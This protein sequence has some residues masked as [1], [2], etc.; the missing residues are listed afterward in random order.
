MAVTWH[1]N[2]QNLPL[3]MILYFY[4]CAQVANTIFVFIMIEYVMIHLLT[5]K[6]VTSAFHNE[7]IPIKQPGA[8]SVVADFGYSITN[9]LLLYF[10]WCTQV[11]NG[12]IVFI[13]I[14]YVMIHLLT[15]KGVTSAFH[16]E[17]I[18]INLSA[19]RERKFEG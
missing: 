13:I 4:W 19:A 1:L 18:P 14:E 3:K 6:G 5:S 7:H 17:Q 8:S 15:S 12:I 10:Y 2:N 16:N 9:E 11:A